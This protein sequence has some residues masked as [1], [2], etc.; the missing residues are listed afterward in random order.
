MTTLDEL[1]DDIVNIAHLLTEG[2]QSV[3]Y[4]IGI[5]FIIA[6][7]IQY[8]QYRENP[9]AVPISRPIFLF[10]IGLAS[11]AFPFILNYLHIVI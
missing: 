9:V 2:I 10:I 3:F 11:A 6:A 7:F 4:I 5:A 8:R 1:T